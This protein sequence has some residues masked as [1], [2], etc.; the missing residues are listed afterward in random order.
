M[1]LIQFLDE[2]LD[3][4]CVHLLG[5]HPDR[6]LF[7]IAGPEALTRSNSYVNCAAFVT[8]IFNICGEV[9]PEIPATLNENYSE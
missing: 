7:L 8:V 3:L 6:D 9:A 4:A 1:G 2:F 5:F